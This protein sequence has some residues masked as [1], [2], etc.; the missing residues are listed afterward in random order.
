VARVSH[1]EE[2]TTVRAF[3]D[4]V[5]IESRHIGRR[6]SRVSFSLD[7]LAPG[8]PYELMVEA[9]DASGKVGS[10]VEPYTSPDYLSEWQT[11]SSS[12][13][14]LQATVHGSNT[15]LITVGQSFGANFYTPRGENPGRDPDNHAHRISIRNRSTFE[16]VDMRVSVLARSSDGDVVFSNTRNVNHLAPDEITRSGSVSNSV[17]TPTSYDVAID[18][19]F[20]VRESVDARYVETIPKKF[21]DL[22]FQAD[23]TRREYAPLGS[24]EARDDSFRHSFRIE[25]RSDYTI[26]SARVSVV[27]Y[28]VWGS[29]IW[30][31]DQFVYDW[32]P[33]TDVA[34]GMVDTEAIQPDSFDVTVSDIQIF[35]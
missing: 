15:D 3:V 5:E 1:D 22:R 33:D 2:V 18:T 26:H 35:D 16:L 13:E 25:N 9:E 24:A 21:G 20:A 30:T 12:G 27:A 6:F 17:V 8:G 34:Q 14:T 28:D 7:H 32:Y 29:E 10:D 31:D 19:G 4:G 11:I 23:Y